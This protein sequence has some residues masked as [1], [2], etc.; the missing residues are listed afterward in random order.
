MADK[1][2]HGR[3]QRGFQTKSNG[4]QHARKHTLGLWLNKNRN[5]E[6]LEVGGDRYIRIPW[7]LPGAALG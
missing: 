1:W 5:D 2:R 6:A 7:Q 4:A 3:R